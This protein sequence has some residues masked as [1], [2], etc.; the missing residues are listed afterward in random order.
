MLHQYFEKEIPEFESSSTYLYQL[1][2]SKHIQE[3]TFHTTIMIGLLL[4][5]TYI[6][7]HFIRKNLKLSMLMYD[8]PWHCHMVE[9]SST[10]KS[11]TLDE[12]QLLI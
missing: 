4:L 8:E 12:F 1:M 2:N 3:A 6:T 11:G 7:P 5:S 10:K 9:S